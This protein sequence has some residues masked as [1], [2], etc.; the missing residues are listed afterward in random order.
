MSEQDDGTISANDLIKDG[1]RRVELPSGVAVLVG[2][3]R[4][5]QLAYMIESLPDVTNFAEAERHAA[6]HSENNIRRAE[7]AINEVI[8][9][10]VIKPKLFK[11]PEL[12]PTPNDFGY[13]DQMVIFK[14]I[15]DH[16]GF[17]KERMEAALPLSKI[18]G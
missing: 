10:G 6:M 5:A 11:D 9:H 13:E 16:S 12:G 4:V 17:S 8:L 15:L 18:E 7:K 14:A 2:K 3:V 1:R